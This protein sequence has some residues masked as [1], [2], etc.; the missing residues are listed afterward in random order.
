MIRIT[1]PRQ[2]RHQILKS[3]FW[4]AGF[5]NFQTEK[6][7]S[8]F[9][10]PSSLLCKSTTT[11]RL[12]MPLLQQIVEEIG[13]GP[14]W[15]NKGY[16]ESLENWFLIWGILKCHLYIGPHG[17]L[18]VHIHSNRGANPVDC[19]SWNNKPILDIIPEW[20]PLLS[21]MN[22][23]EIKSCKTLIQVCES[24]IHNLIF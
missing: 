12:L 10:T 19:R 15:D 1:H 20:F 11:D 24:E 3:R 7:G 13:L 21:S 22:R 18:Q 16:V 17:L 4:P 14:K 9:S 23:F 2:C 8:I 5:W 6:K